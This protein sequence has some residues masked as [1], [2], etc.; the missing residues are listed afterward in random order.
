MD[1]AAPV[2]NADFGLTAD[3]AGRLRLGGSLGYYEVVSGVVGMQ[4][5]RWWV[6]GRSQVVGML[7]RKERLLC[8]RE[9]KMGCW[10][11]AVRAC[12]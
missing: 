4:G 1:C 2:R 3:Y 11:G 10:K 9:E 7:G 8:A 5:R 12:E 6:V